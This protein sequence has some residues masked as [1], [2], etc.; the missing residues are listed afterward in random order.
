MFKKKNPDCSAK[1][2]DLNYCNL[3]CD[4]G[5][6]EKYWIQTKTKAECYTE[7]TALGCCGACKD[8]GPSNAILQQACMPT[9][10]FVSLC[11]GGCQVV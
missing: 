7:T 9:D 10:G 11:K 4:S 6:C 1:Q 2:D 5:S 3:N 8:K